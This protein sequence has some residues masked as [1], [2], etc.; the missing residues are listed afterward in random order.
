MWFSCFIN[1]GFDHLFNFYNRGFESI[2]HVYS[3]GL[4]PRNLFFCVLIFIV[5][6]LF[7][8]T[9]SALVPNRL[10]ARGVVDM[11]PYAIP[12]LPCQRAAPGLLLFPSRPLQPLTTPAFSMD[13]ILNLQG[14]QKIADVKSNRIQTETLR[15]L[16][17]YLVA[18]QSL[19]HPPKQEGWR[20]FRGCR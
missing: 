4:D 19:R 15:V 11:L 9:L 12:I 2:F 7:F 1:R 10:C 16:V 5:F 14:R 6:L 17:L 18:Y 20:P 3:R 13:L 8:M